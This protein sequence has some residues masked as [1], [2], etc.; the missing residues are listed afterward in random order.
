MNNAKNAL[1]RALGAEALTE[2]TGRGHRTDPVTPATG[3]PA[4]NAQLTSWVGLLLLPLIAAELVTLLDVIG[5]IS[6]HVVIGVLLVGV[7]MLK[8]AST[9]WRILRYYTGSRGYRT[10]GPPPILL[11]LLGPLVIA[12]TLGVL[13]SGLALIPVGPDTSRQT[14]FSLLGQ[15]VDL[16]TVHQI[17]FILFA[18]FIGLHLLARFVPALTLATGRVHRTSGRGSRVPGSQ[19]R[20]LITLTLLVA[21]AL[22][23][24]LVLP[25]A[26]SWHNDRPPRDRPS[27][28]RP[29]AADRLPPSASFQGR[30]ATP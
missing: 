28:D 17:F 9:G 11:R 13:G 22:A 26:N 19:G 15:R 3:G 23:A 5:L 20:V 18:V 10:A 6:W 12:S 4:G 30:G 16:V 27:L 8:T 25:A 7:A 14:L 29:H 2:A 21:A 1:L 24:A